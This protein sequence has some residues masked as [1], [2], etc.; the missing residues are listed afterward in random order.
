MKL[1]EESRSQRLEHQRKISASANN[2][3]KQQSSLRSAI[4]WANDIENRLT[5]A[6]ENCKTEF[7][8]RKSGWGLEVDDDERPHEITDQ[9]VKTERLKFSAYTALLIEMLIAAYSFW[10]TINY[11]IHSTA[12]S[13]IGALII[14]AVLTL[15]FAWAV[16]GGLIPFFDTPQNPREGYKNLKWW[17]IFPTLLSL[18][19]SVAAYGAVRNLDAS[20][21]LWAQSAVSL[22]IYVAIFGFW[23][24]GTG[25]LMA[26]DIH[27]WSIDAS[28]EYQGFE[29]ELQ[30][31][32]NSRREWQER[33]NRFSN[34]DE[35]PSNPPNNNPNI[36]PNV[37]AS[38]R[39]VASPSPNTPVPVETKVDA[40]SPTASSTNGLPS[41]ALGLVL[42]LT[43]FLTACDEPQIKKIPVAEKANLSLV[44][45]V[46]GIEN[47]EALQEAGLHV[48]K[49]LPKIIEQFR[50]TDFRVYWFG[51]NGWNAEE[52][53]NTAIPPY[54]NIEV[55]FPQRNSE[56]EGMRPDIK[57]TQEKRK[58]QILKSAVI[59]EEINHRKEIE[60]SLS[61][62]KN[63]ILFPTISSP[64]TDI[65]GTLERFS[66][67]LSVS[68]HIVLIITDGRQNCNS[69]YEL[70]KLSLPENTQILF[71]IVSGTKNDGS[72]DYDLR[73]KMIKNACQK[74][75]VAPH[76][77]DNIENLINE[78]ENSNLAKAQ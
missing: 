51:A 13:F 40:V 44:V 76:Y 18:V 12:L 72:E 43:M 4:E 61:S 73:I 66:Q 11:Y 19:V 20:T 50:I 15:G 7:N 36:A 65:N 46:S 63:D 5:I 41:A 75:K 71:V 25:L 29:N 32:R 55:T 26:A 2:G 8:Q 42:A 54:N 53:W 77:S 16:H 35:N 17:I 28:A 48:R 60:Q 68:K 3:E 33:L 38:S 52:K 69:I 23:G 24:L 10:G 57:E 45:D 58:Q 30:E 67:P 34:N 1:S 39:V 64:C 78:S 37:A 27:D 31:V 14:A 59:E 56:L 70:K 62:M 49:S 47:K 6:I 74:C 22:A 9:V 21:L